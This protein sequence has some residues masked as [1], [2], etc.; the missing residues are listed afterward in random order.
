VI[1]EVAKKL[2][3]L[4]NNKENTDAMD[5]YMYYRI[6]ELHKILEQSEQLSDIA[7]AQGAIREVRRLKN[8]RE[9]VISKAKDG[10]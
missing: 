1:A 4:V 10:N 2:L 7:K 8:L 3:K 6:M 5:T 9:E